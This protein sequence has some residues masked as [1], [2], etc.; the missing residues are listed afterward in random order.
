MQ[1]LTLTTILMFFGSVV[2]QIFGIAMLPQTKGLTVPLPTL[3]AAVGFV[4]G[5][6]LLARLAHSGVNL[7]ILIPLMSTVIPLASIGLGVFLYGESVSMLK[8]AMLLAA[9]GLIGAASTM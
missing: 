7:S 6:A 1:S 5:I 3:G 9:C 4:G 2:L 8:L